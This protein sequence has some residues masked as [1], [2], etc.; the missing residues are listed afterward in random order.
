MPHQTEHH[1]DRT[2]GEHPVQSLSQRPSGAEPASSEHAEHHRADRRHGREDPLGVPGA[3]R[4]PEVSVEQESIEPGRERATRV[5]EQVRTDPVLPRHRQQRH[6]EPIAVEQR[7]EREHLLLQRAAAR[8]Q[9]G[10]H[11]R[12]PDPRQHTGQSDLGDASEWPIREGREQPA[13]EDD[14]G[15][16]REHLAKDRALIVPASAPRIGR[17]MCRDADDEQEERE[18][19]VGRRPPVPGGVRER[20]VDRAPASGIVHEQHA[21]DGRA[22]KDVEGKQALAR[23]RCHAVNIAHR[24]ARR[25]IQAT[26][27][28][29]ARA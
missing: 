9:R 23:G 19:Q 4:L 13:K 18:D 11:V 3:A 1:R 17:E 12:E 25:Y 29:E 21:G 14:Q 16:A 10:S 2:G 26:F 15:A 24:G 28:P 7:D 6:G 27:P 5:A 20:R 8:E 22:A